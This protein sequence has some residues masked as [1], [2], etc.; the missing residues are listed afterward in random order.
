MLTCVRTVHSKH[1]STTCLCSKTFAYRIIAD[2]VVGIGGVVGVGGVGGG[3]VGGVGVGVG[4]VGVVGVVNDGVVG[5]GVVVGVGGVVGGVVGVV[6]VGGVVACTCYPMYRKVALC[7]GKRTIEYI[8][9]ITALLCGNFVT[10]CILALPG[11][12]GAGVVVVVVIF[13]TFTSTSPHPRH[14]HRIHY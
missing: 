13:T 3:V 5:V 2:T 12:V 7:T 10:G 1:A 11:G 8:S 6:V 14:H 4:V 9:T